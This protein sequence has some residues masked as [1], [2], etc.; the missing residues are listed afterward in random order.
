MT[1]PDALI[2]QTVSNYRILEKLGGG[3]MGVVYKAVDTRLERPVA[4]KFLP[5][6]LAHDSRSLERFKREAKAASALNHP[7]ICTIYDIGEDGGKAFIAM[8]YLEGKTLRH[9]TAG[10]PIEL[11]QLLDIAIEVADALEAAH[12]KG[13]VHRDIKP[14][15]IFVTSHGHAKILDFGLAKLASTA[16]G[17]AQTVGASERATAATSEAYLTSPGTALGTVAYMSPEQALGKEVDARTDLFSFGA[18]LYEMATGAL[19]FRG[20]TTAAIFDGILHGEPTA[21]VRLNPVLPA[22]LERVI[23]KCLEKDQEL[24]YQHASDIRSDLRRIRRDTSSGKVSPASSDLSAESESARESRISPPVA[25]KAGRTKWIAAALGIV[26]VGVGAFVAYR[27]WTQPRGFNAQNMQITKLTDSGKA[28]GM[29]ISPDGRYIVYVLVDGEQQSLWVRNVATKSDV[30]V[31]PPEV[32]QFPGV[33]FSPDGNYI[34]FVHS[35]K[36]SPTVSNLYVMPV[37]GGAPR[38]LIEDIDSP[39]SFSPDGKQFAFMRGL[40]PRGMLQIRIANVDGSGDRLLAELPAVWH[41]RIPP[42]GVAWS[43]DGKTIVAPIWAHAKETKYVLSAIN[44]AD[45]RIREMISGHEF[46]G[47][48]AWL[49]NGSGLIVPMAPPGENR[50]QLWTV[51]YPGNELRRLSN[52]LADYGKQ[53]DLTRDGQMLVALGR[54]QV[55]HIWVLPPGETAK[56]EQITYGETPDIAVSSGPGGRLLVRGGDGDIMVMNADGTGRTP[57][58]PEALNLAS[59]SSCGDHFVVFDSLKT[60][61][62]LWRADADGRNP[63]KLAEEASSSDC[64]PDGKWVVY[65]AAPTKLYRL[66]VEGGSPTQV[67][68]LPALPANAVSFYSGDLAISPDSKWIA[69]GYTEFVPQAIPKLGVTSATG[70]SMS[71]VFTQPGD[72]QRLRWSP[73]GKGLQYLLTRKGATNVW[74]QSLAGGEPRQVTN[75]TSGQIFDFSWTRDGKKLLLARGE[76]ASDVVLFR[77]GK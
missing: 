20:D 67:G 36:R 56:A 42:N 34:Y 24:R 2:G 7:N 43:P 49:P 59:M 45:G 51:S 21:V 14:A 15:N 22:E 12:A 17:A 4:L 64:S 77:S 57:F 68:T 19:P 33:S 47:R 61:R 8:E 53:V 46:I 38:Q 71:R 16:Q 37:L 28:G 73:D 32:T 54:R 9:V 65:E 74:E 62:Q 11:E 63:T 50:A 39:V 40:P 25:K 6:H 29:A 70:G 26:A 31:L 44:V 69:C 58:Q 30:Q 48:P 27:W 75:F 13:I 66:A 3:G 10:R 60:N 55:S 52:D 35:S 5:E 72:A 41:R 1:D 23:S 76:T 18:V